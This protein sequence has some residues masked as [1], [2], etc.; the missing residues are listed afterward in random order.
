MPCTRRRA[1]RSPPPTPPRRS[2]IRRWGRSCSWRSGCP[3]APSRSPRPAGPL[4]SSR[5]RSRSAGWPV[6]CPRPRAAGASAPPAAAASARAP[7]APR[8]T[9]AA[10]TPPPTRTA[11]PGS[12]GRNERPARA[13]SASRSSGL[14]LDGG[15]LLL[16]GVRLEL[17]GAL[18]LG[19]EGEAPRLGG[20]H[21]PLDV[22]AVQVHPVFAVGGHHE[23]GAVALGELDGL[24][25]AR[26][27]VALQRYAER[28]GPGRLAVVAAGLG[29]HERNDGDDHRSR[30]Q[31]DPLSS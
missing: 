16:G 2:R 3:R 6:T 30:Q 5:S 13:L 25:S 9:P 18:V 8:R 14:H 23:Q 24:G 31:P 27:L 10:L 4:R 28:L 22:P 29:D 26:D 12:A 19:F 20:S 11:T 21:L 1:A 7:P 15:E 17:V